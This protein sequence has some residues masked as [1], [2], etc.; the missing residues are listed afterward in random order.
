MNHH[1][2]LSIMK[3]FV[4]IKENLF[5]LPLEDKDKTKVTEIN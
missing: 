4:I 1:Y 5:D 3:V 2:Y